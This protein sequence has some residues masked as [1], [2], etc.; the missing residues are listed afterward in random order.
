MTSAV[1]RLYALT[2]A[3]AT[4]FVAWATVAAHPWAAPTQPVRDPRLAA[5]AARQT[6]VQAESIRVKK[7]VD[8]RWALYHRALAARNKAA[9]TQPVST[10]TAAPSVR[11]VT[12]PPLVVTRTS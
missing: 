5:L 9:A 1:A 3:I 6:Q 11:V 4:F 8:A 10:A 2:L 12:L 7:I